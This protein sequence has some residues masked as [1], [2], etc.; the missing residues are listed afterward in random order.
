MPCRWQAERLV[1]RLDDTADERLC[2]S[3]SGGGAADQ[4]AEVASG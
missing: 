2:D 4:G 3:P 1:H